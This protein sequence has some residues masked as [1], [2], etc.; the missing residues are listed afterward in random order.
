MNVINAGVIKCPPK[1]EFAKYC[2]DVCMAKDTNKIGWGEIG[3]Q[4]VKRS[5]E[6]H[7]LMKYVKSYDAFCPIHYTEMD[8]I[9]K[10]SVVK[11]GNSWYGIHLWNEFWRR[12]NINK[13]IPV[14]GSLYDRLYTKY[15][16][17]K[18]LVSSTQYPGYG[19]A[20]TNAYTIIKTL[21]SKTY[22]VAGL[23]VDNLGVNAD[24]DM[25]GGI[26]LIRDIETNKNDILAKINDYLGGEPNIIMGKNVIAP[27]ICKQLYPNAFSIYLVSGIYSAE[28]YYNSTGDNKRTITDV[29]NSLN[30]KSFYNEHAKLFINNS[31]IKTNEM[32]NM[33]VLNSTLAKNFFIKI[34]PS[35]KH[36]VY[37]RIVDTTDCVKEGIN[38]NKINVTKKDID[39]ILVCSNFKRL[40]KNNVFLK[41]ILMND[42]FKRYKKYIIGLN[43]NVLG[44]L[45]NTKYI[46]LIPNSEVIKYLSRSKV[47]LFP[48]L[49]DASPNTVREALLSKCLPIV[50]TGIGYYDV[51][52][53]YLV[54][55]TL[56]HNEW[57]AKIIDV[58]NNYDAY[59]S[60]T[61]INFNTNSC[62][63]SDLVEIISQNNT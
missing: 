12:L 18:I 25:I 53:D 35:F 51:F 50:S 39:I 26:F 29:L 52:P 32:V 14:V 45:P 44:K 55:K 20:A 22:N 48:S 17:I 46:D 58:L 38:S 42:S 21:R 30:D 33:I 40:I 34:H 5:V 2:Y 59:L 63:I 1:S 36:K 23:F 54:C 56:N 60:E 57:K 49:V 28:E 8:K 19:G 61:N 7:N 15:V 37:D 43:N 4:L 27:R 9:I 47:L 13:D 31:E 3:P 24:P 10:P 41:D 6:K 62:N 16:K 11:P